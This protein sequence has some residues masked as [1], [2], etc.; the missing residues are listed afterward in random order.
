[1]LNSKI[2]RVGHGQIMRHQKDEHSNNMRIWK[3]KSIH[4]NQLI[5]K[6]FQQ[7]ILIFS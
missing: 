3:T 2:L 4:V 6:A 7:L 1:M 5:Y